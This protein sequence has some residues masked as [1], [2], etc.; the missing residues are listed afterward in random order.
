MRLLFILLILSTLA[1]S[2]CHGY[3]DQFEVR[4]LNPDN[5]AVKDA[6][7]WIKFDPGTSF[8]DR[9][10]I[11]EPR[12]SNDRGRVDYSIDN[13]GTNTRAIDC[14]IWVWARILDE[15]TEKIIQAT[16]HPKIVDVWLDVWPIDIYVKNEKGAPLEN[17]TIYIGEKYLD[18]NAQGHVRLFLPEGT[19]EYVVSYKGEDRTDTLTVSGKGKRVDVD[20]KKY[21]FSIEVRDDSGNELNATLIVDD[22][23]YNFEGKL[24]FETYSDTVD[25]TV[26]YKGKEKEGRID[27]RKEN[28][29]LIIFDLSSP[30]IKDI[31]LNKKEDAIQIKFKIED[32]GTYPSLVNPRTIKFYYMVKPPTGGQYGEELRGEVYTLGRNEYA[33]DLD[34]EPNSIISFRISAEDYEGNEGKIEGTLTVTVERSK[35]PEIEENSEQEQPPLDIFYVAI[36]II[37][38]ILVIW[39]IK[40]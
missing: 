3:N 39:K 6:E 13:R 36:F 30:M 22:V 20:F 8:G 1:W 24:I 35:T 21:P 11:T 37:L 10:F 12:L 9:Y 18:T 40:K 4:V 28:E 32:V 33:V 27:L 29:K 31:T 2:S 26:K 19:Y 5:I 23:E 14:R 25:Y 16:K 7:V 15:Q 34:L 38:F 17:A